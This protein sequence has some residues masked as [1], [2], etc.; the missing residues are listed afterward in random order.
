LVALDGRILASTKGR[1]HVAL[2]AAHYSGVAIVQVVA[3]GTVEAHKI[4]IR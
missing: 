4:V 1:G 3:N 2:D